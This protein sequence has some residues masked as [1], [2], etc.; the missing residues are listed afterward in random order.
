MS[1]TA[2]KAKKP[3]KWWHESIIDDMLCFPTDTLEERGKR[4]NYSASYLSIIINTDMF[5]AAYAKRRQEFKQTMDDA[6]ISKATNVAAKGL[7]IMLEI[8][9][10]KRTQLPFAALTDTVDKTLTRLGYGVEK[11]EAPVQLNV[12]GDRTNVAIL[13][14]VTAEQ[15]TSARATL[16]AAEQTRADETPTKLIDVTPSTPEPGES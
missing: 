9:E 7:D 2:L 5:K 14:T 3:H 11:R 6:L 1:L 15:L 12:I 16:R 10:T 4:L 8:M 13:P